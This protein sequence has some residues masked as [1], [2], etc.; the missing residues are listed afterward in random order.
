[1][2]QYIPT[3]NNKIHLYMTTCRSSIN[4]YLFS[5]ANTSNVPT[6][7][8]R[9]G[10]GSMTAMSVDSSALSISKDSLEQGQVAF[11]ICQVSYC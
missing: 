11:T 4:I 10:K 9:S 2:V 3:P 1:M 8:P 7:L 6:P 5:Q